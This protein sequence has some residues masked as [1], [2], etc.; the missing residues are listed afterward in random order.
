MKKKRFSFHILTQKT[1][2]PG[3]QQ[4]KCLLFISK[5]SVLHPY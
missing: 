2:N 3:K 4:N 5:N 1:Y